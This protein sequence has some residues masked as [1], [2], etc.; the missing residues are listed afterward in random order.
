MT[1]YP[2]ISS[3]Q[4]PTI[5]MLVGLRRRRD[6]EEAGLTLVE[7]YEELTVALASGAKP[8]GLFI[9]AE[10]M[11]A[12]TQLAVA[13]QLAEA[14]VPVT[15][16]DRPVFEKAA[17][18]EGPDG[19]LATFPAI[20][21]SLAHLELGPTPLILVCE[22]VEKPGNLGAM[23]RTAD[24]VGA[25]A[26]IAPAAITDWSNPNIVRA[27]KGTVFTVPVAEATPAELVKWLDERGI[28]LLAATPDAELSPYDLD[29]KRPVA[30]AVGSEKYGLSDELMEAADMKVRIP[31][32]GRV[33]SLNVATSGAIMLY[34][35]LRQRSVPRP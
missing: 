23:L 17:Y 14:G 35:A 27:S 15:Q 26:V 16:L 21:T 28:I 2:V 9:C 1:E 19:W 7:G 6:R 13:G 20:D 11:A 32:H 34:E 18:R 24:A 5:K 12:E 29:L 4:N 33:N 25:D 3:L 22:A 30:I 8:T 31:M 10:L